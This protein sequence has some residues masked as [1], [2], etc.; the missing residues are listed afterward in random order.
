MNKI[1]TTTPAAPALSR[2]ISPRRRSRSA[3]RTLFSGSA[4]DR[5]EKFSFERNFFLTA[6]SNENARRD[7]Q[8]LFRCCK[9]AGNLLYYDVRVQ[10]MQKD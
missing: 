1:D 9:K 8:S 3:F 4:E 7:F 2:H 5:A 6:P 10:K